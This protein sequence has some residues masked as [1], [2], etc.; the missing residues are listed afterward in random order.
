MRKSRPSCLR[1]CCCHIPR[2]SYTGFQFR[3]VVFFLS[4]SAGAVP[5]GD[6]LACRFLC[7]GASGDSRLVWID[8]VDSKSYNMDEGR[9]VQVLLLSLVL[10]WRTAMFQLFGLYSV[11]PPPARTSA[12]PT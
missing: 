11:G 6:L 1:D 3:T 4:R 2:L 10:G 12:T 5:T 7:R 9:L 8:T